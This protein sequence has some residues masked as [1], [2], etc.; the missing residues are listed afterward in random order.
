MK[1]II[2]TRQYLLEMGK[3]PYLRYVFQLSKQPYER[4]IVIANLHMWKLRLKKNEI[5]CQVHM[6]G[7]CGKRMWTLL[8]LQSHIVS[9]S[10]LW[11]ILFVLPPD[12]HKDHMRTGVTLS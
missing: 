4:N 2:I 7:D 6:S 9:K 12:S 11:E 5:I 10:V 3:A 1:K 8:C